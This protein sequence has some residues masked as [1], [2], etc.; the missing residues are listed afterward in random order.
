MDEAALAVDAPTRRGWVRRALRAVVWLVVGAL[1]LRVVVRLVGSV[2]WAGVGAAFGALTWWLAVPLALGLLVRQ[3]LNAVPLA[4]Y[5]P[6]LGLR[7]S[8]LNDLTAN[9]MGTFLPPPGDVVVRVAMFRS[10]G[11]DPVLGMAASTLNSVTFYAVRFAAPTL[12][13]LA[14]GFAGIEARQWVVAGVG[15]VASAAM[16]VALLL[17][18]RGDRLAAWV[19]RAAARAVRPVWRGADPD[20]WA[21]AAVDLGARSSDSLRRGLTPALGAL[22]AMVLADAAI[23]VVALRGTGVPASALPVLDVLAAFLL[24]YPLTLLPLF[25][26][27]LLDAVLLGALTLDAGDEHEAAVIAALVVWRAVTIL[28]TLALGAASFV[29]W[30]WRTRPGHAA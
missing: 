21:A 23:L 9:L 3:V 19:G 16:L 12:G 14:A 17:V 15:L 6:G 4:L 8:V 2:D 29:W 22:A 1:A 30:R 26:F 24:A 13:L 27:G 25:G 20:A 18:L 28:G 11:I 7:R 5:V 10:W